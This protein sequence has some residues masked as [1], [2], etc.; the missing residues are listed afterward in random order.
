MIFYSANKK[1]YYHFDW[2]TYKN[3]YPILSYQGYSTKDEFWWHYIHIGELQG[4]LYFDINKINNVYKYDNDLTNKTIIQPEVNVNTNINTNINKT[5]IQPEVTIC[6][7]KTIYYYV[8]FVTKHTNRTGIQVVTIYLAKQF[9]KCQEEF[10]I[11]I[12]FVKWNNKLLCLEPCNSDDI[13]YLF[14]YNETDD[15]VNEITYDNYS[16]IQNNFSRP[17]SNCIFFCPE[18]TFPIYNDLPEKLKKYLSINNL[19]SI[20][21]LYDIIPLILP[22]YNCIREPFK[23][24]MLHNLLHANKIITISNFT[25]IEFIK[26]CQQN[27]LYSFNFPIVENISLPHQ[28]R[29]K[30][31]EL[32]TIHENKDENENEQQF[33]NKITILVPGTVEPRKQQLKLVKIFNSFLQNNSSVDVE[34]IIFGN[35]LAVLEEE[36]NNEI[37]KSN[38]KIKYLGI[39]NNEKLAELYGKSTFSCFISQYEGFG[40]PIAESLWHGIPVLTS[41]FGSMLEI[42]NCGGC[43]SINSHSDIEIYD[44][45]ENLIKKPKIIQKLRSEINKNKFITW[46]DYCKSIYVE[47]LKEFN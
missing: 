44:A 13:Y 41:N 42:S 15:L 28:Y 31:K 5:I 38:G 29:N 16:P 24:Y 10:Y 47:I 9:L 37:E 33:S 40:F 21:I 39:I 35:V 27:N 14:N 17:L 43:Y 19:K 46:Y 30:L 11:D 6:P 18:L 36:I 45:L 8:D 4:Y 7:R 23:L 34:M 32:S 12:I 26:Y 2:E 1:S 20:F 25:K 3:T 22:D